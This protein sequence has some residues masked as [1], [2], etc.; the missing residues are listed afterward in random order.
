M[1]GHHRGG[2]RN[3]VTNLISDTVDRNCCGWWT[4]GCGLNPLFST[5]A[6]VLEGVT[7]IVEQ[8]GNCIWILGSPLAFPLVFCFSSN[9]HT[10]ESSGY[11]IS[12]CE[13]PY[14]RPITCCLSTL[15]VPCSQWYVRRVVL[16]NDMTKYKLWQGYHDGP[17]CCARSCP[18]AP[19]TIKSGTYGEQDCPNFFLCLEVYVLFVSID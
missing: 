8:F 12:M 11:E 17:Q 4:N 1:F 5:C 18:N 10:N 7:P 6:T 13:A 15:C 16:H 19:I 2:G 9:P 3:G 14:K